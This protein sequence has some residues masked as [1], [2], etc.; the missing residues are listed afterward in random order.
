MNT[1]VVCSELMSVFTEMLTFNT[2]TCSC[3]R[4]SGNL[5][6]SLDNCLKHGRIIQFLV[7]KHHDTCSDLYVHDPWQKFVSVLLIVVE[8]NHQVC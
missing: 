6:N 1:Y 8:I 7:F 5:A 3:Q 4:M 2:L